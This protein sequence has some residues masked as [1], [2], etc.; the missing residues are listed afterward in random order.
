MAPRDW[1]RFRLTGCEPTIGRP[2]HPDKPSPGGRTPAADDR[3][4]R[5]R[6]VHHCHAHIE[7]VARWVVHV[8]GSR[9]FSDGPRRTDMKP[10]YLAA[11]D[12][13]LLVTGASGFIGA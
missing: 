9:A 7:Q 3:V 10:D 11:P 8:P 2:A 5:N 4:N 12:D 6:H 1:I 13:G